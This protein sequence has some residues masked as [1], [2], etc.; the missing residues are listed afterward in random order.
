[1]RISLEHGEIQLAAGRGQKSEIRR[2]RSEVRRHR[3]CCG[4]GFPSPELVEG[5]PRYHNSND[6]YDFNDLQFTIH[7]LLFTV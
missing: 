1:M 6:F 3:L 4:S 5:Q 2:Q 7:R